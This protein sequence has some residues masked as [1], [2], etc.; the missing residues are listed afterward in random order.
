MIT[1]ATKLNAVIGNP[2]GHSL[3]P[4][5][6][7]YMYERL[8]IDA[9]MLAFESSD[10]RKAVNGIKDLGIGLTAV[11][12]PFKEAIM[13]LLGSVDPLASK[14]GAVNTVVNKNGR[15]SGYNTDILGIAAALKGVPV[16]GRKVLLLGAGGAALAAAYYAVSNGGDLYYL[17][18]TPAKAKRLARRFGGEVIL[19]KAVEGLDPDIIV[20]A[21]PIGMHPKTDA[22]PLPGYRFRK[23]QTVF[24][25]IYNPVRTRLISEAARAGARAVSGEVMFAHQA[26]AQVKLWSGKQAESGKVI[27][28]LDKNLINL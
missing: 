3:S 21:T 6:H 19:P 8:G 13:P 25:L 12:L 27:R 10:L 4:L 23:G 2:L 16:R 26:I 9:V 7:N 17:N 11:T 5:L 14:I 28:F 1:S 15:L 24:D 20:N 18:R 22:T